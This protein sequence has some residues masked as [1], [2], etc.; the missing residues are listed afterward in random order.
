MSDR[1]ELVSTSNADWD[2]VRSAFTSE[3]RQACAPLDLD[4]I[5]V[6]LDLLSARV[7]LGYAK[8][9]L[10]KDSKVWSGDVVKY[11][12]LLLYQSS[13]RNTVLRCEANLITESHQTTNSKSPI[14]AAN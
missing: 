8:G 14:I 12:L 2:I 5:F 10:S 9:V 13:M 6:S 7:V 1:P 11:I 3:F 4:Y